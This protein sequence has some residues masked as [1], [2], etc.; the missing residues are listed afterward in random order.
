MRCWRKVG[1]DYVLSHSRSSGAISRRLY[2]LDKEIV[3]IFFHRDFQL[4]FRLV[5]FNTYVTQGA[6]RDDDSEA[7][8][9]RISK[10]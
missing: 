2:V 7:S 1:V 10:K 3:L 4:E 6:A 8:F 9:R 5:E